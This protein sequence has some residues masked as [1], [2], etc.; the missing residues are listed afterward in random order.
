MLFKVR[1]NAGLNAVPG[2]YNRQKSPTA[3]PAFKL[4]FK[5]VVR[6]GFMIIAGA[7]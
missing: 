1:L 2:E 3:R 6:H 4:N 5:F 7:L